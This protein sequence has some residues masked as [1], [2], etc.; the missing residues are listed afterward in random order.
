[1][2][3]SEW[4]G[5]ECRGEE[6]SRE[7]DAVVVVVGVPTESWLNELSSSSDALFVVVG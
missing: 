5:E 3:S 6:C 1:M 4:D 7:V 2:R